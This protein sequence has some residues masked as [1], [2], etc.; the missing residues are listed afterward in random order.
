MFKQP[1]IYTK[2]SNKVT[3]YNLYPGTLA[4]ISRLYMFDGRTGKIL[5]PR[6]NR[7]SAY[8]VWGIPL[9][10]KPTIDNIKR[11]MPYNRPRRIWYGSYRA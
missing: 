5:P 11:I 1:L 8:T 7:G 3:L 6:I 9:N 10:K 4:E 2:P